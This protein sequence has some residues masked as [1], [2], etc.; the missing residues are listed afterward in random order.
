M[1]EHDEVDGVSLWRP[2]AS[3]SQKGLEATTLDELAARWPGR[4]GWH[5]VLGGRVDS[6]VYAT[7]APM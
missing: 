3:V 7:T 4:G 6:S 5:I 1:R 2:Y